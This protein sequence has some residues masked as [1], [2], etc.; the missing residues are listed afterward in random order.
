[1]HEEFVYEFDKIVEDSDKILE[2]AEKFKRSTVKKPTHEDF[3]E[4]IALITDIK[5]NA[6]YLKKEL[7]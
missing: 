3:V 4:I 5:K 6:K 7:L 1:M 2:I